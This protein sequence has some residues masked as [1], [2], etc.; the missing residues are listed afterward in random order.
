VAVKGEDHTQFDAILPP[1]QPTAWVQCEACNKWR[2]VPWHVDPASLPDDW[3]C[4][5][6]AWDPENADCEIPQDSYDS[7]QENTLNC[8]T[9]KHHHGSKKSDFKI[10]SWRDVFGLKDRVYHE[11]QVKQVKVS[12]RYYKCSVLFNIAGLGKEWVDGDSD[13]IQPHNTYTQPCANSKNVSDDLN[14]AGRKRKSSEGKA[15]GKSTKTKKS[16]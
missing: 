5:M 3:T 2:R 1:E 14:G 12:R 15:A 8:G 6:N 16:L 7:D 11:A 13:R 4:L 10:G 9:A